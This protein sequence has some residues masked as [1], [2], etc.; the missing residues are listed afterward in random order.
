MKKTF[1]PIT[2]KT[3]YQ[4]NS[5]IVYVDDERL[6][7]VFFS[8]VIRV[9]SIN[10]NYGSVT[11]F[12]TANNLHG[13]TNGKLLVLSEMMSPGYKLI[14]LAES[15]LTKIGMLYGEDYI[16]LEEQLVYGA[17]GRVSELLNKEIPECQEI[18]WLGSV[19]TIHGNLIWLTK[20][21]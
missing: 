20:V 18:S 8:L 19:I 16:F 10:N 9:S 12:V 11:E 1:S 7:I 15:L 3:E 5:N 6:R 2:N 21:D 4:S 13:V 14:N 17:G